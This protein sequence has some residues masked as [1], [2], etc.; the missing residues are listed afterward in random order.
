[1]PNDA[2]AD[3]TGWAK[4]DAVENTL[5]TGDVGKANNILNTVQD[6]K[7][8]MDLLA[9]KAEGDNLPGLHIVSDKEGHAHEVKTDKLTVSDAGGHLSAHNDKQTWGQY[10]E[11]K[12]EGLT[13]LGSSATDAVKDA[14]RKTEVGDALA[15]AGTSDSNANRAIDARIKAAEGN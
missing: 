1:M 12:W 11:A 6:Q 15:R 7:L 4:R 14:A 3:M 10:F 5:T 8:F 13:H 2:V 9:S